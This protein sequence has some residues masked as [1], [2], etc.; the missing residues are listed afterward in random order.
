MAFRLVG[1]FS[2]TVAERRHALPVAPRRRLA[3][4]MWDAERPV[5]ISTETVVTSGRRWW[6]AD[7]T[8][9]PNGLPCQSRHSP[10]VHVSLGAR[11]RHSGIAPR[12][13]CAATGKAAW[14]QSRNVDSTRPSPAP[15]LTYIPRRH[16]RLTRTIVGAYDCPIA[17]AAGMTLCARL[18]FVALR[19]R[20]LGQAQAAKTGSLLPAG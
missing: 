1:R 8:V 16:R 3:R 13:L 10:W 15:I 2:R 9:A 6:A 18:P 5:Y 4:C 17:A 19:R 20:S 11:S 7:L 14:A 12:R